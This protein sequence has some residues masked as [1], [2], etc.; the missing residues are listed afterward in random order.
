MSKS[1]FS[2]RYWQVAFGFVLISFAILIFKY[3]EGNPE[4]PPSNYIGI[5]TEYQGI[6]NGEFMPKRSDYTGTWSTKHSNGY[7]AIT[8]HYK[9]GVPDGPWVYFDPKGH[10][11]YY[12]FYN[13][14][15][16]YSLTGFYENGFPQSRINYVLFFGKLG[17]ESRIKHGEVV[18]WDD[19]GN[20]ISRK[21]YDMGE[22]A[23]RT[24][25]KAEKLSIDKP[26]I[27][28][29]GQWVHSGPVVTVACGQK[30]IKPVKIDPAQVSIVKPDGG[31]EKWQTP[32]AFI[33]PPAF[34]CKDK[35]G[36]GTKSYQLKSRLFV[37]VYPTK[38]SDGLVKKKVRQVVN[39]A[40]SMVN[41]TP[42]PG[43]VKK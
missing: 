17:D 6:K 10:L 43:P 32:E 30:D 40:Q 37:A 16:T 23:D 29:T 12:A 28:K 25:K 13:G 31:L 2:N 18:L 27:I 42:C 3:S 8:G 1:L 33:S 24:V 34:S 22:V 5:F 38:G 7:T 15:E 41:S 26:R 19:K 39:C 9:N 36:K 35:C 14:D 20:I 11:K 21:N 4:I